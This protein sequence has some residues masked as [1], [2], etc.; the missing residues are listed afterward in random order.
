[1]NTP[2]N[3]FLFFGFL[4]LGI[5]QPIFTRD[6]IQSASLLGIGLAFDPSDSEQKWSERPTRQKTI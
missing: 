5:Y 4:L 6:Y 2:F 3:K 1:M